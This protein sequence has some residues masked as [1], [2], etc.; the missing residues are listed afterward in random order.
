MH[1]DHNERSY[2]EKK[3]NLHVM[4][5]FS[6]VWTCIFSDC[7]IG[8]CGLIVHGFGQDCHQISLVHIS[9]D[10]KAA[11]RFSC[12]VV[13]NSGV[14]EPGLFALISSHN[15]ATYHTWKFRFLF[16]LMLR[17]NVVWNS[18]EAVRIFIFCL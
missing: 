2:R 3:V 16:R 15:L 12:S 14:T 17:S 8:C 9:E 18:Y 5:I 6:L 1:N 10:I 7:L 11:V 13:I 4:H